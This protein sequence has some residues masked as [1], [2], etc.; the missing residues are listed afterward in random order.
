MKQKT[1][2]IILGI[3][4]LTG[5][6][7]IAAN[8]LS[9]LSTTM[10]IPPDIV[11]G[12]S[13]LANFSF[14]YF[15]LPGNYDGSALIIKLNVTSSDE[16][17]YPI[18]KNDF[19]INGY[20]K[21]CTYT[22]LGVCILP[23]TIHFSCSEI[24]QTTIDH[25]RYG[26][27]T[28]NVP[29]GIF[30]CFNE[31]NDLSLNEGNNIFLN[32][33]SNIALWPGTYTI[34]ATFFYLNDTL[35]PFVN[36][37]NKNAF[38]RYYRPGNYLEVR[39]NI[40]ENVEL[41]SYYGTIFGDN[42]N[43]SVN[44]WKKQGGLYYFTETSIPNNLT[45]G[46][47]NLTITAIDTSGNIGNDTIKLKLDETGP[48]IKVLQP[49]NNSVYSDL[50]PIKLN[51]TDNKSGVDNNSVYYELTAV[52][53]GN[54]CPDTGVGINATCPNTHW[55]NLHYN[56]TDGTY[57]DEIN[58]TAMNLTSGSYWLYARASDNL[59]NLGEL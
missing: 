42:A 27:N 19:K 36:I 16:V 15:N 21:K 4:L 7:L 41:D 26:I 44:F 31:S 59:G 6:G 12:N 2:I 39:A 46:N 24:N 47:Y 22:I 18:W 49:T 1:L 34:N 51:V 10:T 17:N 56:N 5:A 55:L 23:K 40:T 48:T 13:F 38:D 30:Y 14:N 58:T 43:Y 52:I 29:D 9:D 32:I 33:T 20:T 53:N 57:F 3:I 8:S 25:S 35:A 54:I 50:L 37:T 45:E 11:S 28:L